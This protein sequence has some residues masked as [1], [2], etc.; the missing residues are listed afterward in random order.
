MIYGLLIV[1][2]VAFYEA[3][4]WLRVAVPMRLLLAEGPR[5]LR[6]I[7]STM[8]DDDKERVLR[9]ASKQM[10]RATAELVLKVV[11]ATAAAALTLCLG[12]VLLSVPFAEVE[13]AMLS[14]VSIAVL[15]VV[16]LA[17]AKIRHALV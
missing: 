14:P 16:A 11:L 5:G 7:S 8:S 10:L 4:L 1:A 6:T 13:Q 2:T 15:V 3:F 9:E 17:Y 12:A